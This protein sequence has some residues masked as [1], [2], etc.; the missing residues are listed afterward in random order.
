VFLRLI[1]LALFA[2]TLPGC[3]LL[4]QLYA[5]Y[6]REETRIEDATHNLK[7]YSLPRGARV[8]ELDGDRR[9]SL[10]ATPAEKKI[11]YQQEVT[12]MRPASMLPFWLGTALDAALVVSAGLAVGNVINPRLEHDRDRQFVWGIYSNL[13]IGLIAEAV[14]GGIVGGRPP[15]VVKRKDL[16]VGIDLSLQRPGGVEIQAHLEVPGVGERLT[17]PLDPAAARSMNRVGGAVT[18]I[19]ARTSTISIIRTSTTGR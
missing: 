12:V 2:T 5:G 13:V 9:V 16:P 15:V 4:F 7:I 1:C 11:T 8:E 19:V 10:G 3:G 6:D 14:V 17:I 18:L